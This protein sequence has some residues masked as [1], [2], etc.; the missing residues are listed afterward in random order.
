MSPCFQPAEQF[1]PALIAVATFP[2]V[3]APVLLFVFL[4]EL[5]L[6]AFVAGGPPA[7]R[8]VVALAAAPV[9]VASVER[10]T[11]IVSAPFARACSLQVPALPTAPEPSEVVHQNVM[12]IH[13]RAEKK[14]KKILQPSSK[15]HT[16]WTKANL[17]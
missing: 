4:W 11:E 7:A 14:R 9:K 5:L 2:A 6:I 3:P 8:I 1:H 12:S 17:Q 16:P 10:L 15:K 13:C